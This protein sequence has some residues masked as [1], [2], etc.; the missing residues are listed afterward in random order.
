[1]KCKKLILS[2]IAVLLML[3]LAGCNGAMN[4]G[5]YLYRSSPLGI[6]IEYPQSWT[7]QVDLDQKV[8]AF[9]TPSEGFG[10]GYRDNVTVSTREI[11][12]DEDFA[13]YFAKYYA[14]LPATFPAFTEVEKSDVFVNDKEAYKILFT[15]STKTKDD[16]GKEKDV[17]LKILQYIVRE[18]GNVYFVTYIAQPNSYDYFLPYVNTMLDTFT[19]TQ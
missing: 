15:S 11:G 6:R 2:V 1:M 16:K 13:A 8:V 12:E 3:S 17:E 18:K 14:S 19:I 4:K 7:K 5:F 9:V 10:D